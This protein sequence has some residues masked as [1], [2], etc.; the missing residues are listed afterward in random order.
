MKLPEDKYNSITRMAM[1]VRHVVNGDAPRVANHLLQ[2]WTEDSFT[3]K[4]GDD[5]FVPM[6]PEEV[7][8]I[9]AATLLIQ[10]L[11]ATCTLKTRRRF[12]SEV[13][14]LGSSSDFFTP[15]VI[16]SGEAAQITKEIIETFGLD[17]NHVSHRAYLDDRNR[18]R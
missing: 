6:T 8:E 3:K 17:S 5:W 12:L 7:T 1:L 14:K 13:T 4:A 10:S 15:E 16:Q 2:W 9:R 18:N 11:I